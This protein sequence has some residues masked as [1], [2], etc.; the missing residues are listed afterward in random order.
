MVVENGGCVNVLGGKG[1]V[2]LWKA[3]AIL[4]ERG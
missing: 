3:E 4:R 1:N 2:V